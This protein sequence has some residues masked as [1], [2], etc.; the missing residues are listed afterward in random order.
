MISTHA[1]RFVALGNLASTA[2]I[3]EKDWFGGMFTKRL[4]PW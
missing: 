1:S 3:R 4:A 2:R